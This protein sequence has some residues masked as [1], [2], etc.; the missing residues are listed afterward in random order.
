MDRRNS[1]RL[2]ATLRTAALAGIVSCIGANASP[3]FAA[4]SG[5]IVRQDADQ[6]RMVDDFLHYVLIAK[7]DLAE[8]TGRSLFDSGITD[9]QLAE[10]V[11]SEG[12][13]D[14]VERALS[15]GR[16]MAGVGPMVTRFED[17]LEQGRLDLARNQDRIADAIK[18]LNGSLR[19]QLM[20]RRRLVEAG[21][22]AVPAL[23]EE[24]ISTESPDME[25]RVTEVLEEIKRQAVLPLVAALPGLSPVVQA[26]V[27]RI[28]SNIGWPTAIPFLLE[29]G[30]S[31]KASPEVKEAA[32]TA[33]RRLG[34]TS[35]DVSAAFTALGTKFFEQEQSLVAYPADPKNMVWSYGPHTGLMPVPV[36]TSIYSQV[37]AMQ[38]TRTAL[39]ADSTN[40]LALATF[41]ASDLRRENQLGDGET[42]P[43]AADA[44]YSPQF[45]ATA[46]GSTIS[47]DVLAMA[48]DASDTAL[49]RDAIAALGMT[50]GRGTMFPAAGRAPLL[51]CLRYPD[52]RVQYDAALVLGEALPTSAFTGDNLVVPLLA[53]AVRSGGDSFAVVAA[54]TEEDRNRLAGMLTS[55]GFKVVASGEAFYDLEPEISKA[56]GIDLVLIDGAP[57]KV[58]E[59]VGQVRSFD[60]TGATPVLVISDEVERVKLDREF[61][62]DRATMTWDG[63]GSDDQFDAAIGQLL[64]TAAGGRLSEADAFLYTQDALRTLATIARS[65]NTVFDIEAAQPALIEAMGVFRGQMR[66]MVA[67]VVALIGSSDCQRLLA[68]TALSADDAD[69]QIY[70]LGAAAQNAQLFGNR[71]DA[72]QVATLRKL[73]S[74]NASAT[75]NAEVA[76]AA[77]RFYGALDLPT[78]EAVRLITR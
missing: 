34:G 7:P 62:Q 69:D 76:D 43:F 47:R 12:L 56:S 48:I 75:G 11:R 51:E 39:G 66:L 21:E 31:S 68:E 46:A 1:L 27:C 29:L 13:G 35:T 52:R 61:A 63:G 41:V 67:D 42:D 23:L 2:A 72:S 15:R 77:G 60:R 22:Y 6:A 70:L 71:L 78:D 73:I 16:G 37:M 26:K 30:S 8:S 5:T 18:M 53:S 64:D 3:T 32:M 24:L 9:A 45:F 57:D 36:P 38:C 44:T 17:A 14:K 25:L 19:S 49:I 55:A 65:G 33:F 59:M 74:D 40:R 10:V 4:S 28:L 54:P 58:V 20:A 50:V